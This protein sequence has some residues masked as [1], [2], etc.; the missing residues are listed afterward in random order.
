LSVDFDA[1]INKLVK[2]SHPEPKPE[3]HLKDIPTSL[4]EDG[5]RPLTDV[6]ASWN[7]LSARSVDSSDVR[8]REKK[9]KE[10]IKCLFV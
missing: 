9:R 8:R 7:K 10:K 2:I 3:R 4:Y 5:A 1:V 6:E